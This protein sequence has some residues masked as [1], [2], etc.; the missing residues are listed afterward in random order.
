MKSKLHFI[1]FLSLFFFASSLEAQQFE[2]YYDASGHV[3][4]DLNMEVMV[5]QPYSFFIGGNFFTPNMNLYEPFLQKND[6]SGNVLFAYTLLANNLSNLRLFD[7]LIHQNDLVLVG[8]VEVS[9]G[10]RKMFAAKY[11]ITMN[12]FTYI[13]YYDVISPNFF[14][15]AFHVIYTEGDY[16]NDGMPDPG[17]VISG[18]NIL[19]NQDNDGILIRT[20][21]NLR[22]LIATEIS[23]MAN[24]SP[25]IT[26]A[27]KVIDTGDG[28][29]VLGVATYDASKSGVLAHKI[30]YDFS[31]SWDASYMLGNQY[32]VAADA[33]Y[34]ANADKIYLLVNYTDTYMF[35]V[36]VLNNANGNIISSQ[37]WYATSASNDKYG[38]TLTPSL[39]NANNL[40]ITGYDR[41]SNISASNTNQIAE[42]NVIVFEFDKTNG[43]IAGNGYQYLIPN[44]EPGTDPYN[45]WDAQMPQTY[46]PDIS[47]N[48]N[49]VTG[50]PMNMKL[51]Y[52][53]DPA[54]NVPD[55]AVF[56]VDGNNQNTCNRNNLSYT[57]NALTGQ[58]AINVSS[59]GGISINATSFQIVMGNQPVNVVDCSSLSIDE[60]KENS[61][62][63]YPNPVHNLLH[64]EMPQVKKYVITDLSKR[65]VRHG[66]VIQSTIDVSDL[67]KGIYFIRLI[68]NKGQYKYLRI[69]KQ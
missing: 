29:F 31:Q 64:L 16:N 19:S 10:L 41:S 14:T 11:N 7:M 33:Y 68:L 12:N 27:S 52:Y 49:S 47:K 6:P 13:F 42:S 61:G 35:G 38:F 4:H 53:E 5:T 20:D 54:Y 24:V 44:T 21:E 3:Y 40:V 48:Y 43:Q 58:T 65:V 36:T 51:G 8:S 9:P 23:S 66:D 28:Y 60:N 37:S 32:D 59:A 17:Y 45:F 50:V 34:D 56:N 63:F 39:S 25:K 55:L 18:Y 67:K 46:Y 57:T 1:S 26:N 22:P 69:I 15:E 30:S 62:Q 2:K